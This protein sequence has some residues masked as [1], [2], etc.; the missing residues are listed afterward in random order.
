[1]KSRGFPPPTFV[2]EEETGT[3]VL[4]FEAAKS[5][6]RKRYTAARTIPRARMIVSVV[7]MVDDEYAEDKAREGG[8]G[9]KGEN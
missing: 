7:A 1:M 5:W 3:L 4:G 2:F 9:R 8:R 6:S